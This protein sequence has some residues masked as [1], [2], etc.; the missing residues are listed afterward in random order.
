M[1]SVKERMADAKKL[2]D[3]LAYV[4]IEAILRSPAALKLS[5]EAYNLL[6]TAYAIHLNLLDDV[7]DD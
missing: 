4:D 6:T 7:P 2:L 5:D 3:V 1:N